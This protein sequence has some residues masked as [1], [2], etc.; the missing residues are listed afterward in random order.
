MGFSDGFS[1]G[2]FVGVLVVG[3]LGVDG[4]SGVDGLDGWRGGPDETRIRMLVPR[5]ADPLGLM[6][7]KVP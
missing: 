5:T 1:D 3:L 2:F 7:R 6:P 4:L